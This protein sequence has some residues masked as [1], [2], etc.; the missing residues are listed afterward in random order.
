MS[1]HYP[2]RFTL[3]DGVEVE[4]NKTGNDT[5]NFTMTPKKGQVRTFTIVNDDRPKD[6]VT[7][8]LDFDQL[9]A[10]RRF[11]LETDDTV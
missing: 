11:W 5:Y 7:E 9:N 10:V 2:L 1:K 6:Q 8:S 3:E 4:V